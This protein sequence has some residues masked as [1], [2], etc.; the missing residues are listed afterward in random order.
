MIEVD[1]SHDRPYRDLL[2]AKYRIVVDDVRAY[3]ISDGWPSDKTV[4]HIT[5]IPGIGIGG[6]EVAFRKPVPKGVVIEVLSAWHRPMMVFDNGHYYLVA[7]EDADFP[8]DVPV[9]IELLRGNEGGG[10][11]LNHRV[12]QKLPR[13]N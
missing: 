2:G 11:A 8:P 1:V 6:G 5:L 3:G 9:R 13:V 7:V 10:A 12:Y 4:T